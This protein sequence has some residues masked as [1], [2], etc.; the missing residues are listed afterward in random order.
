MAKTPSLALEGFTRVKPLTE[1]HI[2]KG[3]VNTTSKIT[4]RPPAPAKFEPRARASD[5]STTAK[6]GSNRVE[7]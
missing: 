1:G 3:G 7:T 4:T 2:V 6:P 5:P